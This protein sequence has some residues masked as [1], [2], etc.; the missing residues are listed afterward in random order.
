MNAFAFQASFSRIATLNRDGNS[1]AS[2]PDARFIYE[3]VDAAKSLLVTVNKFVDP[4][5]CL[6]F[7]PLRYY[8]YIVYST[9][10]L[11]KA[12]AT[13]SKEEREAVRGMVNGGHAIDFHRTC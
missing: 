8:T 3:A 11:Y 7:L 10:F 1:V 13:M 12:L 9:V 5:N 4:Q 6:R 2:L